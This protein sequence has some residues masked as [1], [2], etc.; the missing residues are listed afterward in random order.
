MQDYDVLIVGS[1]ASGG[2]AAH[3]LTKQGVK[4]LMLDAGPQVDFQ[5]DRVLK[6]VYDLPYRGF[7]K[8][9]RLSHVFQAN[10]FNANQWVDEQEVPYTHAPNEPYNWVRVRMI[11]GKSNFWA[12]M[13]FRLSDYE[14][15]AKDFDGFG[16]NWPIDH[17]ELDPFYT[18]VEEIFRVSGRKEGLKQL[19][20][21][22]FVPDES[23]DSGAA[24]RMAEAGK[25]R[26]MTFT[27]I[28]R[29]LGNGQLASSL[30]LTLPPAMATGNLTIVP[31][32]VAREISID[33]N[34]GLVN[35]VYYVDRKSK[36]DLFAKAKYVIVAA[37][38]LESTRLLLNSKIA[39]SSGALGHYLHD[40]FYITQSVV[41]AVPE[42]KNG[43]A[44]RG[45][46]GGAGY[47]PRFQNLTQGEKRNFIRGVAFDFSTGGSPDPRILP[48]WGTELE[49]M[50]NTYRGSTISATCM[51]EVLPRY[52]NYCE[53]DK[54]TV[55]A[56][57]I[58][59]LRFHCKY[60]DNEAN[61][62]KDSVDTLAEVCKDAGFE[63]LSKNDKPF[64]PGYSIHELGTCRM[65]DDPKKGVLNRWNQAHDVKNLFVVDGSSFV[66]GGTQNP[67]ITI[68][69]LAMRASEHLVSQK[70]AGKL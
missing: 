58:P 52:E 5:K 70:R 35:G 11:G 57:G 61:M 20:D 44:P 1:G 69:A 60:T 43:K 30:N 16:E 25:S 6:N 17:A 12:R 7:G 3:T 36:R 9:G 41:A 53:I 55:D 62:A 67:T 37:S 68:M 42:A 4:C 23:P 47:I 51:G 56:Y 65:S 38:C 64:P 50:I 26:N 28:R 32:A 22:N 63:I 18:R 34:T 19:P 48:A 59:V 10:E 15:K 49:E 45:L 27:K 21:G 2:M 24:K 33:K 54:T 13:S 66:T 31:N 39:N 29:S 8:P 40:Q 46:M 14:F